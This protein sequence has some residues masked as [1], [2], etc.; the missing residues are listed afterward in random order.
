MDSVGAVRWWHITPISM[1]WNAYKQ[2][3]FDT[4]TVRQA[5]QCSLTDWNSPSIGQRPPSYSQLVETKL[6]KNLP[7]I[8]F[9][10]KLNTYSLLG[11]QRIGKVWIVENALSEFSLLSCIIWH[12]PILSCIY[13]HPTL[14]LIFQH[15]SR[16]HPTAPK[17][18]KIL[19]V[20]L[21]KTEKAT[22]ERWKMRYCRKWD[23][24]HGPFIS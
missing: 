13:F 8:W 5:Y 22:M 17:N 7:A 23:I 3:V 10:S 20:Q 11:A 1:F 19:C 24:S 9:L 14:G 12:H 6:S 16:L 15:L 2:A 21:C 18:T 4:D